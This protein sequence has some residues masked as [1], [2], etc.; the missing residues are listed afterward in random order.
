[1]SFKIKNLNLYPCFYLLKFPPHRLSM[2]TVAS[3]RRL[4]SIKVVIQVERLWHIVSTI[5][6]MFYWN[7]DAG[8]AG[9]LG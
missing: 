8:F 2:I 1:M 5:L 6:I 4:V 7:I 9:A 3:L